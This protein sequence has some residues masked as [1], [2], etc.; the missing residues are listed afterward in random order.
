MGTSI[1]GE[2]TPVIDVPIATYY[3]GGA[4]NPTPCSQAGGR[5]PLTGMT[6]VFDGAKLAALYPTPGDYLSRLQAAV[7][8]A[9]A[10]GNIVPEGAADLMRRAATYGL[11]K[12]G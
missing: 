9:L 11:P 12:I 4:S 5:L 2:R 6:E 3:G 1:T 10:A 8:A 7:D